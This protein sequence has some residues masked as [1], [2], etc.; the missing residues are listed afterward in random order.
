MTL[1]KE[2]V[3]TCTQHKHKILAVVGLLVAFALGMMVGHEGGDR[4]EK[5]G[6]FWP[7]ESGMQRGYDDDSGAWAENT[8]WNPQ[9]QQVPQNPQT[10]QPASVG[11]VPPAKNIP[12]EAIPATNTGWVQK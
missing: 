8:P 9:N 6:K 3:Q 5:E 11:N 7:W 10:P 4:G 1:D 2:I 12:T